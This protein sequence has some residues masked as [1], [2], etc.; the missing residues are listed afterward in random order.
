VDYVDLCTFPNYR[1][2]VVGLC[3]EAGKHVLVQKP[4]AVDLT[5]ADRMIAVAAYAGIRLGWSASIGKP[6]PYHLRSTC[7]RPRPA[8]SSQLGPGW[9]PASCSHAPTHNQPEH[10]QPNRFASSLEV[11][12]SMRNSSH[13][14]WHRIKGGRV[15]TRSHLKDDLCPKLNL[16]CGICS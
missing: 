16:S 2:P 8:R 3:A 7:L 10:G 5:T 6:S 9:Q 13:R 14:R 11:V 12:L 4:L 1:L 15:E